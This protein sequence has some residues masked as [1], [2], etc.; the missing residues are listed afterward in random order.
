MWPDVK[1]KLVPAPQLASYALGA[2][3]VRRMKFSSLPDEK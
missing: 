2:G 1:K 3:W